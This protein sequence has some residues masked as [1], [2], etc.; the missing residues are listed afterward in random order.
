MEYEVEYLLQKYFG[1]ILEE[2]R[3]KREVYT[4]KYYANNEDRI[5]V[6]SWAKLNIEKR[7]KNPEIWIEQLPERLGLVECPI[8]EKKAAGYVFPNCTLCRETL[9]HSKVIGIDFEE[10]H[11]RVFR[12]NGKHGKYHWRTE[13][14]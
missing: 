4:R 1:D 7:E 6:Y 9:S 8:C 10:V 11:V 12:H 2:R 5:R 13:K 14:T 3:I